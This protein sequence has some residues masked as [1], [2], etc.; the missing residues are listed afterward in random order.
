MGFTLVTGL[1]GVIE[2]NESIAASDVVSGIMNMIHDYLQ[3][4]V[5]GEIEISSYFVELGKGCDFP[6]PANSS[7]GIDLSLHY[8]FYVQRTKDRNTMEH[9]LLNLLNGTFS[10]LNNDYSIILGA[11]LDSNAMFISSRIQ[12]TDLTFQQTCFQSKF[13]N[14]QYSKRAFKISLITNLLTCRQIQIDRK[15]FDYNRL[16]HTIRLHPYG[17][18]LSQSDFRLFSNGSTNICL[19]DFHQ[20]MDNYITNKKDTLSFL[21]GIASLTLVC[22]SMLCLVLTL[23]T[24]VFFPQLRT[25]PG[26]NNICLVVALFTSQGLTQ[27][28]LNQFVGSVLCTVVGLLI[29]YFWLVTF[30][31]M[32]VCSF[33]MFRVFVMTFSSMRNKVE[34]RWTLFRY[35][36]YSFGTPA[37]IIIINVTLTY[38][39]NNN[40]GYGDSF[41]CFLNTT[42]AIVGS[43][44]VPIL[45]LC[46][47]NVVF[48]SITAHKIRNT[49]IV[50]SN[51]E[52]RRDFPIYVKLFALTGITW[53]AQIIDSFLPQSVF[54]LVVAILNASQGIFIFCSYSLN[55]RVRNFYRKGLNRT[56]TRHTSSSK[57]ST[58]TPG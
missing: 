17:P 30:F 35:V 32:N 23:C 33:H 41:R 18:T 57:Y 13:G 22:L 58:D 47:F 28:G 31:C 12:E 8:T 6:Y 5:S 19:R 56:M 54:S 14:L 49:P 1:K 52:N 51:K 16:Q 43:F 38:A 53:I 55:E 24:Y 7:S 42:E 34:E 4:L 27:F 25:L 48:F 36:C 10:F 11:Y 39:L 21:I 37:A 2:V 45:L 29:H 40:A 50:A 20:M 26:K 9:R 46:C 15:R 44:L 3:L